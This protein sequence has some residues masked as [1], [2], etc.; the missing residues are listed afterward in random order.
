[1]TTISTALVSQGMGDKYL[2]KKQRESYGIQGRREATF[3]LYSQYFTRS[4]WS[5]LEDGKFA[6]VWAHA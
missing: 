1:M 3:W 5:Y 2:S 6:S 4:T